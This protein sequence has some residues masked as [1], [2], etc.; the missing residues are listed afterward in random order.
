MVENHKQLSSLKD[1]HYKFKIMSS[2]NGSCNSIEKF[3]ALGLRHQQYKMALTKDLF[4]R[5]INLSPTSVKYFFEE[6]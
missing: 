4:L 1:V 5:H 6:L 2:S 3:G